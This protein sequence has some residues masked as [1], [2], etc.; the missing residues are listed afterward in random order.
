[1]FHRFKSVLLGACL[2]ALPSISSSAA[3]IPVGSGPESVEV[4]FNW[5]DGFIAD[6]TVHYGSDSASTILGYDATQATAAGDANLSLAWL[7]F[8]F[9]GIDPNY[10][11]NVATYT[12]GHTGDGD[13]FDSV[14]APDNFWAQWID[15][16][17]GWTF[18][19][20]ASVDT[21]SNGNRIGWVFGSEGTPV[22][23]PVS[24]ALLFVGGAM[25][26]NRRSRRRIIPVA[27]L[28]V[29]GIL[30]VPSAHAADSVTIV[31][32]TLTTG[33]VKSS[34]T[35]GTSYAVE[36]NNLG[37]WPLNTGSFSGNFSPISY[38][39]PDLNL[40]GG[41]GNPSTIIAFG[42]GG[43]VTLKFASPLTPHAGEKDLGI[44]TAQALAGGSGAFFNSNME[45]AILVS[46]DN[47]NWFTLTGASVASPTTYIA[48]T[49]FLNAPTMAYNYLTGATAWN[50][51][52]GTSLANLNALTIGDFTT[53]MPDDTL[54]NNPTSTNAQRLA[55]TGDTV[56]ADYA[57]IFGTSG[58]GNWFD[59]S[60]SGLSQVNYV[61]LNG[62]NVPSTGG[63]RLDAV[64]ANAAAVP[65]PAT[66]GLLTLSSL[67][68]LKRPRSHSLLQTP[69]LRYSE[70]P[71]SSAHP[72]I[73]I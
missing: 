24:V 68:L 47:V 54:F 55:L 16:G 60:G 58:G 57:A 48:T 31:P 7:N 71:D 1:M 44:F 30:Q 36:T 63:I 50:Y 59:I 32:G 4:L 10:F 38:E 51:G 64:F 43:G 14:N 65:E 37:D 46:A 27:V 15:Q 11:L 70:D 72:R 13:T 56:A 66:L 35:T 61:R 22:P 45:A 42:N 29:L 53:P 21:L 41:V 33:T 39:N 6:Y 26:L 2:A 18:G 28:T 49:F 69:G 73:C 34:L 25:L 8:P 67:I 62:A 9:G 20:G 23:E 3:P 17:S 40:V 52:S 12:G 5:P 19:N